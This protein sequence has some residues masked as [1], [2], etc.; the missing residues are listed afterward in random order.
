MRISGY[1]QMRMRI[2]NRARL[3]FTKI[4]RK[5]GYEGTLNFNNEKK[6]LEIIVG[7]ALKFTSYE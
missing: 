2:S 3:Y 7:G 6:K 4:V 1:K 5:R